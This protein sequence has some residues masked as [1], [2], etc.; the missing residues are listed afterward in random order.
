MHLRSSAPI[1]D[2]SR[3]W[4]RGRFPGGTHTPMLVAPPGRRAR[5]WDRS[6]SDIVLLHPPIRS[7]LQLEPHLEVHPHRSR[8][9]HVAATSPVRALDF[10][11]TRTDLSV[12]RLLCLFL[13]APCIQASFVY[14]PFLWIVW[15]QSTKRF[16][17]RR[18]CIGAAL[19]G[20]IFYSGNLQSH[21]Y[22][23]LFTL[24]LLAGYGSVEQTRRSLFGTILFSGVIGAA[25]A[26]P[27]LFPQL[28]L[29]LKQ[30]QHWPFPMVMARRHFFTERHFPMDAWHLPQSSRYMTIALRRENGG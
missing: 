25:L 15:S 13:W 27:L 7:G 21:V 20:L 24:C 14:Y 8:D 23:P 10:R 26:A 17:L 22:L 4:A 18:A 1:H 6:L 2:I 19:C 16:F 12:C 28:E 5:K 9:V 29:Y 11:A 30:C 3:I